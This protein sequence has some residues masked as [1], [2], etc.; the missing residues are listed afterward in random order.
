VSTPT[1]VKDTKLKVDQDQSDYLH[2]K[3]LLLVEKPK[4]KLMTLKLAATF[5]WAG[6][7]CAFRIVQFT[8]QNITY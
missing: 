1:L 5:S 2:K 3:V 7:T 4:E 8:T 6:S